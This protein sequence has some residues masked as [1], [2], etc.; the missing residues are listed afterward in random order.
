[1]D[2]NGPTVW[3][4]NRAKS[5]W[6]R[7]FGNTSESGLAETRHRLRIAGYV[8]HIGSTTIGPPEGPPSMEQ[9]ADVGVGPG[10]GW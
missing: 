6:I 3:Y 7:T 4:W 1:M 10:H 9:Y 5:Q 8:A 2:T